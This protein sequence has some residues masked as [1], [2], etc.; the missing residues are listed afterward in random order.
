MCILTYTDIDDSSHINDV[1]I[2]YLQLGISTIPI[3]YS[4]LYPYQAPIHTAIATNTDTD[5]DTNIW[6]LWN[7][8][9]KLYTQIQIGIEIIL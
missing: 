7:I 1:L 9:A 5:T 2:L 3:P 8:R 6:Y 4:N